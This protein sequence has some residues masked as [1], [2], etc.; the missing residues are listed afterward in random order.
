MK[1]IGMYLIVS[2]NFF[3]KGLCLGLDTKYINVCL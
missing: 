1:V 2:G 3:S